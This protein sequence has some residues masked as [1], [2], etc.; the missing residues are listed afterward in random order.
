[1]EEEQ[2][3]KRP[4]RGIEAEKRRIA[5]GIVQEFMEKEEFKNLREE[6]REAIEYLV[7]GK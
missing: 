5:K 4:G 7:R 6:Y 3:A 2:V 1:M